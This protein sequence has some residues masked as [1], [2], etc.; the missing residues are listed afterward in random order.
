[1]HTALDFMERRTVMSCL[2]SILR[3][4]ALVAATLFFTPMSFVAGTATVATVAAVTVMTTSHAE[5]ER[6]RVRDHRS[7]AIR[8]AAGAN[9]RPKGC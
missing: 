8:A 2:P 4:A 3:S 1:M 7:C 9:K 6:Q 5:A